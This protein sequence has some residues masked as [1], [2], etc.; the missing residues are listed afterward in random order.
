MSPSPGSSRRRRAVGLVAVPALA[1]STLA[2]LPAGSAS[3]AE[4]DPAPVAAG[5]TWLESQLTDGLIVNT[6]FGDPFNDYGLSIDSGLA[7]AAVGGHDA[8]VDQISAAVAANISGYVGN[9]T[10]ESYA[11][12]LA[13]AAVLADTA[14]DDPTSFGG[15]DLIDRL[16][17]RVSDTGVTIGRIQDASEFGDF[18]NSF[19]QTFAVRALEAA[20]STEAEAATEFL[21]AQQ[22]D[23]G[24]FRQDFAAVDAA[25]Q[26]CDAD[27]NAAPSVDVTALAVL[28]LLPQADDT[29]VDAVVDDAVAWL[30]S[31]QS[32]AAGWF[33]SGDDIPVANANST[34][35]AGWALG[36]AGQELPAQKAAAFVR[37]LQVDEPA[38]C[39]SALNDDQ[40]AIAYDGAA[41]RAGRRD[42][43]TVPLQDQ[44]RRASAQALP[45]LQWAPDS[46]V[47]AGTIVDDFRRYHQ[48]GDHVNVSAADRTPGETVCFTLKGAAA[49]FGGADLGGVTN[50]RV[51]LPKGTARRTYAWTDGEDQGGSRSF[52]VLDAKRIPV[53]LAARVARGERQVVRIRG[54][55]PFEEYQV[56]AGG[57]RVG[58]GQTS[59]KG[60][61]VVR[62]TAGKKPGDVKVVVLGQFKNRRATKTFSV[63]R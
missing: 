44:W 38:P 23:E 11:G 47:G 31:Q 15:V 13:K 25:D 43:I 61:A 33:T 17:A 5:A 18:A 53:E 60:R 52:T 37:L 8:T 27:P 45:V 48:P 7:L 34:G 10:T 54:L 32:E 42:G 59:A 58:D 49:G 36:D 35:L 19:G 50:G 16:E 28:A 1:L 51:T 3:A 22:C 12:S 55:A 9:G 39:E 62:F 30:V 26:D 24:F 40:G 14:G 2:A 29:D 41:L 21:V 56:K 57:K 63:T 4:P 6:A 20:G 46:A